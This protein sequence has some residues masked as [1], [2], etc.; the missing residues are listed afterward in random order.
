MRQIILYILIVFVGQDAFSQN[1][2]RNSSF[3]DYVNCPY[4]YTHVKDSIR[5]LLPFWYVTNNSTP[6]YFNSC[7]R[8]EISGV[9]K[10][11]AGKMEAKTGNAYTGIILRVNQLMYQGNEHYNE[12]L[13]SSFNESLK[14]NQLYCCGF[15]VAFA[16][17]S[18]LAVDAIGMYFSKEQIKLNYTLDTVLY[19]SNIENRNGNLITK[20]NGWVLISG[21]YRAEG[22]ENYLTIGNFKHT[23]KTQT[24]EFKQVRNNAID[25]YAYYYIDDVFVYPINSIEEC[26]CTTINNAR[27]SFPDFE[28]EKIQVQ[29][30]DS[31]FNNPQIGNTIILNNIYFNFD[32]SVLLKE[33]SMELDKLYKML[34][35]YPKMEIMIYGYTDNIGTD[36]YN[37]L[38]SEKR[39]KAVFEYLFYKGMSL[40]RINYI[41][42]GNS[43]PISDNNLTSGREKNRRV[44]IEIIKM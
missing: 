32:K 2:V 13:Q 29:K 33:S 41:G 31:I 22:G 8:N 35:E 1:L 17:E 16:S 18:G 38:L 34:K 28:T 21:I 12:H 19:T 39:A 24:R 4:D 40:Q 9:P 5:E 10:N 14:R 30:S 11:F 42:M 43:N 3:E 37:I 23:Y 7:C 26:E 15:S 20:E 27:D 25:Q 36:S 6:D 44:E